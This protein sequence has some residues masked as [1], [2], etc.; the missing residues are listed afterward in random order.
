MRKAQRMYGTALHLQ[1]GGQEANPCM[2]LLLVHGQAAFV[3]VKMALTG[4]GVW[5][6]AAH[7]QFALALRALHALAGLY[8][9]LLAYH[10]LL[11][12]GLTW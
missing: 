10:L 6:L 5:C 7:Q 2:A 9:T 8:L 11:L 1:D 3:G 12:S 4:A